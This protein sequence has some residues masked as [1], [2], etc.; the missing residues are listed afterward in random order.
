MTTAT[1]A[2]A[3]VSRPANVAAPIAAVSRSTRRATAALALGLG[4]FLL[5]GVGFAQPQLL[6]D[7]AHDSRHSFA[8][9]CH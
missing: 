1:P 3:T 6:H 5:W 8:F 9:A 4:L 7:A 2:N